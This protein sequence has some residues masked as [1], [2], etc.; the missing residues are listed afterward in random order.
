[1]H[2]FHTGERQRIALVI[3][4]LLRTHSLTYLLTYLPTSSS[5]GSGEVIVVVGLPVVF[6]LKRL[7]DTHVS[8]QTVRHTCFIK[9][10]RHTC[11]IKL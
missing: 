9:T 11:F 4:L 3:L 6:E 7:R 1:M 2:A 8:S 5:S 10:A